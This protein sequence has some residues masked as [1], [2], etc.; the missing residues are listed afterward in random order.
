MMDGQLRAKRCWKLEAGSRRVALL[1]SWTHSVQLSQ[2]L[3]DLLIEICAQQ[4]SEDVAT[5]L[6]SLL[7]AVQIERTAKFAA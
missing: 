6:P 2:L 3:I 4:G 1:A 5:V 7:P